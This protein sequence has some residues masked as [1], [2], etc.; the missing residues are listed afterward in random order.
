MYGG[1]I[2]DDNQDG[3]GVVGYPPGMAPDKLE[4]PAYQTERTSTEDVLD[5]SEDMPYECWD[6]LMDRLGNE[7]QSGINRFCPS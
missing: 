3:F 1:T 2:R 5:D 7:I 6:Y 4:C